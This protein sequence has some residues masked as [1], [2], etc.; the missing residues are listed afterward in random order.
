MKPLDSLFVDLP[1]PLAEHLAP[2]AET[3]VAVFPTDVLPD[4]AFG[5][6]WLVIDAAGIRIYRL[7]PSGAPTIRLEAGWASLRAPQ[8]ETLIGGG[9]LM[10]TIDGRV[11]EGLRFS[12]ACQADFSRASKYLAEYVD[13]VKARADGQDPVRPVLAQP[14]EARRRCPRCALLLPEGSQVCPACLHKSRVLLRLA[15]YLRPYWG[16]TLWITL[17]MFMGLIL[18]LIPPY[19]TRPLVDQVLAPR[20]PG[21]TAQQRITWLGW[22][23]AG[24]LLTQLLGTGVNIV[25]SRILAKLGS[26]LSHDLRLK[27]YSHMQ[28][29]SIRFF[30]KRP[31][32]AMLNRV[33]QDTESLEAVLVEGLQVFVGQLL[34]LL[35]IGIV[36]AIMNWKLA[37]L[38]LIPV[39]ICLWISNVCMPRLISLWRR[40]WHFRGRLSA[41]VT[42]S[43][44]G[45]RVIKAFAR[46]TAEIGRFS[47]HSFDVQ[48]SSRLAHQ[49]IQTF[50]PMLWL[51]MS[52]GNLIV[53]FVG[54]R[55]I[56]GG[57]LSLGVL[58]TFLAYL[59]M[60]Y[61]P[62]NYLTRLADYLARSLAAAERVFEIL[63]SDPD[64]KEEPDAVALRPMQGRIEFV[65]VT[66]GYEPHRPVLKNISLSVAPGEMIG[67]VGHSGAG[68][69][70]TMNL[71]CRFYDVTDGEIRIDGIDLRRI[72]QSDL[73]S[74]IGVVLQDTFLFNGT[75]A[76]NI[77][78]ARPDAAREDILA[79]AKAA[80]AHDFIVAKP[81]GYDTLVGERGQSLSG[82][83]RQRVA[84]ARAILHNPRILILDEATASVD[85]DTEKQIQEAIARLI[86]GR[87]TLAIAHR[88]STLRNAHRLVVLKNGALAEVGTHAEL[89]AQEGEFHR[90]VNLQKDLSSIMAVGSG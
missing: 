67:L 68:K 31:V 32:G 3:I 56:I 59:G 65:N 9:A 18:N 34:T 6:E 13:Y 10:L 88:L 43:L 75:I 50:F 74:Q 82:G 54:G 20:D 11:C 22:L 4:G 5:Q 36:L 14:R 33:V 73:R 51:L 63:D 45:S 46:E 62:L 39:P 23:V 84:I 30:E 47:G 78:F 52:A 86:K 80:N 58:M 66:F 85:T 21:A 60:F 7:D 35:G 19:L 77:A 64:V 81:D 38:V 29:M 16:D 69:S 70:T 83:E 61:G 53:W 37:L 25:R 17:L 15:G 76:E 2:H 89:M 71:I 27:L 90:L 79:A 44:S 8:V 48:E 12:N 41:S 87:T 55:S 24:L 57:D 28:F 49:N 26:F 1:R 72:K 42:E 40:S